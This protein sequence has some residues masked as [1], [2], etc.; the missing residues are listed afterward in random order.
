MNH[1]DTRVQTNWDWRA[2][3][4]FMFGGSGSG[5]LVVA[6]LAALPEAPSTVQVLS[7]LIL[8]GAGLAL[9]GLEIGR[10]LRAINVFLHA[11]ASWMTREAAVAVLTFALALAGVASGVKGLL[12]AAAAAGLAFLYCQARILR[13]SK[14]I[15]AWREAA[16]T[17]LIVGTGLAEGAGQVLLIGGAVGGAPAWVPYAAIALL[18]LRALAWV[19]YRGRLAAGR[20]PAGAL[21][22]LGKIN[23]GVLLAGHALPAVLLIA[24]LA[25]PPQAG[26]LAAL[27]SACIVLSGWHMKFS[28]I[29]RA[30]FVQGFAFGRLKRGLP[31]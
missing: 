16:V 9:V 30:A 8:M 4:N 14:G 20:A 12:L 24:G 22:L 3:G 1:I 18:I 28:I 2:A 15:P 19:H 6:A 13:A 23:R 17:P 7:G 26:V 25:L 29:T 31:G 5:L 10:P 11:E 21:E 27:A